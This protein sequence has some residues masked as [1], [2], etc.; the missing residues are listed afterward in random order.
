MPNQHW[1]NSARPLTVWPAAKPPGLTASPRTSSSTASPPSCSRYTTLCLCWQEG[2]VSQDM[3]DAKIVTLYRN[4][5]ERSDCNNYR[6][7]S[8][9][10]IVGKVY[11]R[12]SLA[13]LHLLAEH[14]YPESQ[15]GFRAGRSTVD[16]IFSL[17]QLQEKCEE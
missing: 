1:R 12:V 10:N 17:R 9:L 14:F 6:G 8:L 7:I 11:A 16:M 3:K 13:R 5:G 4:K 2:G 15:R